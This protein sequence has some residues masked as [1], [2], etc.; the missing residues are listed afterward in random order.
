MKTLA[1]TILV[2]LLT[3]FSA[4]A[5]AA[6]N[7]SRESGDDATTSGVVAANSDFFDIMKETMTGRWTGNYTD[8]TFEE[9]SEWAPIAVEYR[10]TASET[11][12]IEDYIDPTEPNVSMTTVYYKDRDDLRLTHYCGAA[13]HPSML[14][15]S[16]D[17]DNRR[18]DFDFTGITNLLNNDD[19]HSRRFEL[20]IVS[21][22][23]IKIQY[24]GVENGGKIASQAYDL[25]RAE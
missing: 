14:A 18:V 25:K 15:T 3:T 19:Y 2:I 8:G 4:A 16:L 9:P 7:H 23:H 17:A 10:L 1:N 11:A 13:N 22:D 24:H 12:I 5:I 6:G 21:A 20:E